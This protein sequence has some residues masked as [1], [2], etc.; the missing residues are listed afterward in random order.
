MAYRGRDKQ[1]MPNRRTPTVKPTVARSGYSNWLSAKPAGTRLPAI[2][3]SWKGGTIGNYVQPYDERA[4]AISEK[5]AGQPIP[6]RNW[7][8]QTVL[9][10]L[11]QSG[12]D[13]AAKLAFEI[14]RQSANFLNQNLNPDIFPVTRGLLVDKYGVLHGKYVPPTPDINPRHGWHNQVMLQN[15]QNG[16]YSAQGYEANQALGTPPLN[17]TDTT[18][19]TSGG[20]GYSPGWYDY[21]SYG[22]GGGGGWYSSPNYWNRYHAGYEATNPT[23]AATMGA[24]A[25]PQAVNRNYA[26]QN[27]ASRWLSLLVNWKI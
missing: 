2:K 1:W 3:S 18:V 9:G 16:T 13:K 14:Q 12:A 19:P 21:P 8:P 4:A 24:R 20:G 7:S 6:S 15:I 11:M 5:F 22:G 17:N 25:V 26:T 10:P 27:Q 23:V